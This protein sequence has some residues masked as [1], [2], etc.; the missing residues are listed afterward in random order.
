[1]ELQSVPEEID[2]LQRRLVQLELAARQLAGEE[3]S[4]AKDRLADI[5]QEM[6]TL[7]KQLAD[8][9]EQWESEKLGVGDVASVR[10]QLQ[11]A[12]HEYEQ[13]ATSVKEKQSRGEMVG[14]DLYQSLYELDTKRR[15][16]DQQLDEIEERQAAAGAKP[17][18]GEGGV[19]KRLLRQE[20]GPSPRSS[21][22][23]PAS[24]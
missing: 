18:S 8:L 6:A 19:R 16:L 11:Q 15:K 12:N 4:H 7:R 24:R 20:V 9:R 5:E 21:A 13:L 10:E 22:R 3:E 14:E 23:G 17:A 1:M 2:K